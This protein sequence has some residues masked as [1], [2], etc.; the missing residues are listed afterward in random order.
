MGNAA[1]TRLK[2]PPQDKPEEINEAD[3]VLCRKLQIILDSCVGVLHRNDFLDFNCEL[4]DA[5]LR[6]L[7]RFLY[8][9]FPTLPKAANQKYKLKPYLF[10][11]AILSIFGHIIVNSMTYIKRN[12][13]DN[14]FLHVVTGTPGLGKSAS[15][16]PFI[17]LL[18]SF[19][20]E[21]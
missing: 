6:D 5:D 2:P 20:V 4:D 11:S 14:P 16:F 7:S 1:G 17:T 3:L 21:V 8:L 19:G 12:S 13:L 10:R 15:R 18:M 9:S